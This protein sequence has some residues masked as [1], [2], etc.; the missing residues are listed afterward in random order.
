MTAR[1][2]RR[3][4]MPQ[5][6]EL[7]KCTAIKAPHFARNGAFLD[8]FAKYPSTNK[9]AFVTEVGGRIT[10][11]AL[12]SLT[13][14][15][16]SLKQGNITELQVEDITS[17]RTLLAAAVAYCKL[18]DVDLIVLVAPP[19]LETKN[20]LKDWLRF[21]T[22]VM[23]VKTLSPMP[24]IKV[25]LSSER[26]RKLYAGKKIAFHIGADIVNVEITPNEVNVSQATAEHDKAFAS[27]FVSPEVFLRIV[28]GQ[29]NPYTAYLNRKVKIKGARSTLS[30]LRLF[31]LM[32]VTAPFFTGLSDRM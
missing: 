8:Q 9:G 27:V 22:G 31:C 13:M 18:S 25:L 11:F 15:Q 29:L 6:I 26:T 10:G 3:E 12:V 23:M 30:V 5:V 17:M 21:D 14:E 24:L 32:R 19:L 7:Y 20:V 16:G 1:S 4:D 28:L 2:F